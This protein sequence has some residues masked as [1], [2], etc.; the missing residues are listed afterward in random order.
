[1]TTS[2]LAQVADDAAAADTT[3]PDAPFSPLVGA[4]LTQMAS[5]SA[6]TTNTLLDSPT[7]Q[8]A[9]ANATLDAIRDRVEGMFQGETMPTPAAVIRRLYP[10]PSV[11]ERYMP[12]EVN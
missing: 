12:T 5:D 8:L 11:V 10:P 7:A 3:D 6:Y 1:M 4:I 2:P 9:E